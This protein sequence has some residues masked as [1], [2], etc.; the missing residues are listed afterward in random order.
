VTDPI[1]QKILAIVDRMAKSEGY[2]VVIDRATAHF[3]RADLDIT[4]RCIQAYN[5]AGKG[6]APAPA[7]APAAP[8]N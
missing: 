7:P 4:D 6:A 2:D 1:V 5:A 8:K 3:V